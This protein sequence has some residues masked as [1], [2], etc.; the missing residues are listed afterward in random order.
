[1][2]VD[3]TSG[4]KQ[5]I[6]KKAKRLA[7][8]ETDCTEIVSMVPGNMPHVLKFAR[9]MGLEVDFSRKNFWDFDSG[10]QAAQLVITYSTVSGGAN[11]ALFPTVGAALLDGA[12]A[13]L[14]ARGFTQMVVVCAARDTARTAFLESQPLSLTTTWWTTSL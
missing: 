10:H 6:I 13:R 14:K 4:Q 12:R 11:P 1:M 8:F 7:D 3:M 5:K 9:T 2:S